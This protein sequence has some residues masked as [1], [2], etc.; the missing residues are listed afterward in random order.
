MD[1]H[2]SIL[3][4][5][6]LSLLLAA[7]LAA[8]CAR[9]GAADPVFEWLRG[10]SVR[11]IEIVLVDVHGV[12]KPAVGANVLA[13]TAGIAVISFIVTGLLVN[14][15][16][17]PLR[18]AVTAVAVILLLLVPILLVVMVVSSISSYGTTTR[19]TVAG[20]FL[21]GGIA[22]GVAFA[23]VRRKRLTNVLAVLNAIG[24]PLGFA[25]AIWTVVAEVIPQS[26]VTPVPIVQPEQTRVR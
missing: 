18:A 19:S 22:V 1:S 7:A 6:W 20:A 16:W 10:F 14:P 26:P 23:W 17:E 8:L 15:F 9:L 5:W 3:S 24:I 13:I 2:R 25:M 4:S 11:G 12:V 21:V